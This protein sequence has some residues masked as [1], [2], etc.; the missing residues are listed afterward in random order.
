M[1]MPRNLSLLLLAALMLGFPS[2]AVQSAEREDVRK[3]INLVTS[4][5]IPFPEDLSRNRAKTERVWLERGGTTTGCIVI[6]ERRWCYEHI[7]PEGNRAEMLRIRNEPSRGIYIGAMY[8]YIVDF[9]LE[10]LVDVGSSTEIDQLDGTRRTPI[11]EVTQFFHRSTNRGGDQAQAEYQK[12][13]DEGIQIALK[14][15]GE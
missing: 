14:N 9:D 3:V 4:V 12:M 1:P 7:P 5:K 8:Y 10:G 13:Y 2:G 11:A 6:D 15:F